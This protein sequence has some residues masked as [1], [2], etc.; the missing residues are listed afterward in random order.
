MIHL[1]RVTKRYGSHVA[2]D[3]I[4]LDCQ[5]GKTQ[6]LIGT[7][8]CGKS[9]LLRMMVGLVKPD[10]GTLLFD[11]EPLLAE[12][13]AEM[14]LRIGYMIQEGGLFPHLTA[15]DNAAIM[16]RYLGWEQGRT[17]ERLKDLL[18]LTQ[19]PAGLLD[20]YPRQLSGGQRQRV[21]LMRALM[22]DPDVLLLD[23]PLG[24]LDPMIRAELQ[25]DLRAIFRELDKTVVLVTHDLGEAGFLGD[26]ITLLR[27]GRIVQQ[28]PFEELLKNPVDDFAAKFVQAQ[29]PMLS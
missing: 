25:Q 20:R 11:S 22:L 7:S 3:G 16:P 19:L 4:D 6:V 26:T 21:S 8:G 1:Q 14:R 2:V 24:D 27:A 12:N 5:S 10:S 15:R 9:T 23:E 29:R 28:G 17:A 18:E 13:L